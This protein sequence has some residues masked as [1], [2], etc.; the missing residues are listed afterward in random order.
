MVY[1]NNGFNPGYQPYQNQLETVSNIVGLLSFILGLQNLKENEYQSAHTEQL[2]RQIDID[3]A[4]HKQTLNL[5]EA[6]GEQFDKQNELL[7][8]I[9]EQ[10]EALNWRGIPAHDDAESNQ[11]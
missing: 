9:L 6:L 4:N 1:G 3:A 8:Q 5:L 10:L 11:Q 7:S 2:I